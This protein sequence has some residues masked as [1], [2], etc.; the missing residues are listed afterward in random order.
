MSSLLTVLIILASLI[1]ILVVLV[2]NS[3]GGGLASQFSASNQVMGVKKTTELI[4]KITWG[5]VVTIFVLCLAL[6]FSL[7]SDTQGAA[8]DTALRE[9]LEMANSKALK[10]VPKAAQQNAKPAQDASAPTGTP[11]GSAPATQPAPTK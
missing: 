6:S 8:T 1:L 5:L 10:N 11:Q 9:Q 3:K 7:K 2:Q 4:E